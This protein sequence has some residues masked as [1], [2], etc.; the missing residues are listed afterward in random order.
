LTRVA[1]LMSGFESTWALCGGWGVDAWLGR[2]TREHVDVDVA[3]FQDDQLAL[4]DYLADG[5]LL[6]GHDPEDDDSTTPWTGRRLELPA[7]I[8]ARA[9][10]FE[11]DFQLNRRAGEDWILDEA[12]GVTL[13][14]AHALRSSPWGLPT[15]AR[16]A[17]LFY[18][19]LGS[20]RA[21]DQADF[22]A[23]LPVLGGPERSWLR[24]ALATVMPGH[25]WLQALA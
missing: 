15:L 20:S 22:E 14:I 19:G 1:E 7:H 12:R 2:R 24:E 8:H 11:L 13:P 10:G 17:I 4:R 21:Q 18:K 5:W 16:E 3:I 23:L 6:N 9:E 25:G